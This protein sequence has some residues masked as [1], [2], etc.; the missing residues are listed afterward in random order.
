M[1]NIPRVASRSFPLPKHVGLIS[2]Q[3]LDWWPLSSF[4]FATPITKPVTT[5]AITANCLRN[6]E[7][8]VLSASSIAREAFNFKTTL[9]RHA[10]HPEFEGILAI[11]IALCNIIGP[12][13]MTTF[14]W[15]TERG[16]ATFRMD[17]TV[18]DE[19]QKGEKQHAGLCGTDAW[20]KISLPWPLGLQ[21]VSFWKGGRWFG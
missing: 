9:L 18:M 6:T 12:K 21:G 16:G 20:K 15:D 1:S 7:Y 3:R 17:R 11:S 14:A 4:L 5:S 19:M 8:G 2:S 13:M 10:L